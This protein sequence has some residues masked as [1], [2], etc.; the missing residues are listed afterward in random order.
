MSTQGDD[1][2][3]EEQESELEQLGDYDSELLSLCGTE[4]PQSLTIAAEFVKKY[5]PVPKLIW[6][7]V[8]PVFG[9]AGILG[10]PDPLIFSPLSTLIIRTAQDKVLNR[11]FKG[12]KPRSLTEAVNAIGADVAAA[13][14]VIHSMSRRIANT[15]PQRV[16]GPL[17]EDALLRT[18]IGFHLGVLSPESGPGRAMLAGFAGRCGLAVQ[19]AVG[20]SKQAEK[21]LVAMASGE[22]M[23]KVCSRIYGCDPLEVSAMSLISAGC[24]KEIAFG[25]ASYSSGIEEDFPSPERLRWLALFSIIEHLRMNETEQISPQHWASLGCTKESRAII[26]DEVTQAHRRG[27]GLNWLAEPQNSSEASPAKDP[28]TIRQ[29]MA[30]K[31]IKVE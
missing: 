18:R 27:H 12:K 7:L 16:R 29:E 25:I 13:V 5:K 24:S 4:L 6:P 2:L 8:Y 21:A 10:S 3:D 22:D 20:E 14:C 17:L 31:R 15:L 26:E 11:Q 1:I 23:N 19:I 30:A 9:K 28:L